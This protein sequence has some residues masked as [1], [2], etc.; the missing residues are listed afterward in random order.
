MNVVTLERLRQFKTLMMAYINNPDSES[1]PNNDWLKMVYPVGSIYMST[2]NVS[3]IE[4]FGF[5]KWE[6]IKDT[7]LLCA[8][9]IYSAGST[10]GESEHILTTEE[11]PSHSHAY[12]RHAFDRNDTDPETGEDVYGANNK[13]LSAHTGTTEISGGG[14]AH[15]N[16]PPYLT[17]YAWRR[18]E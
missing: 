9:D 7:F 1:Y 6:Q 4:L 12:K 2:S 5:G 3:P 17:V 16:M 18:V 15:N 10:G 13:T 11:M 14:L 8:G